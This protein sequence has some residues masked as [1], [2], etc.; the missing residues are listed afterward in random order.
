MRKEYDFSRARP[1]PYAAWLR[2]KRWWVEFDP[3][4][5]ELFMGKGTL[6]ERIKRLAKGP[7]RREQLVTVIPMTERDYTALK[8]VLKRIGA[9]ATYHSPHPNWGM[10]ALRRRKAG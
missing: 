3:D 4:L 9:K 8:S 6:G 10:Q 7:R 5:T 2:D 1:S